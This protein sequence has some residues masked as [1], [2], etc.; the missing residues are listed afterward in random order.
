MT[1]KE[2]AKIRPTPKAA[3]IGKGKIVPLAKASA[4]A[5]ASPADSA[6]SWVDV[7]RK[8]KTESTAVSLHTI[9]WTVP[10]I[11]SDSLLLREE[12]VAY[13]SKK[14]RCRGKGPQKSRRCGMAWQQMLFS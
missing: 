10:A 6:A 11:Q 14:L 5:K 7:I 13:L 4:P 8:R 9:D 12:G 1:H 2:T 3:A